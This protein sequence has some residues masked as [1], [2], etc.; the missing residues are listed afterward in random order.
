ME[1]LRIREEEVTFK[2]TQQI[3]CRLKI[4]INIF[5]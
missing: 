3:C 5:K 1:K 2:S 4:E